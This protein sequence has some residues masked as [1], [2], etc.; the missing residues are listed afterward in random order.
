MY[1]IVLLD[2]RTKVQISY[3]MEN[4][5]KIITAICKYEQ[6][7]CHFNSINDVVYLNNS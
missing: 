4:E 6:K 1:C 5:Y 3:E 7:R 2:H